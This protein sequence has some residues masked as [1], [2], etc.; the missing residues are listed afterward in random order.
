M[1]DSS[2]PQTLR[3]R[4]DETDALHS[5]A[6]RLFGR[7]HRGGDYPILLDISR[8]ACPLSRAVAARL[9]LSAW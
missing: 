2:L 4:L 6:T 7:M 3:D 1:T 5:R 9:A 8:K